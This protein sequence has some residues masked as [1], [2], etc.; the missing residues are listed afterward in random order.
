MENMS[1]V[2]KVAINLI[3]FRPAFWY[4]HCVWFKPAFVTE[5]RGQSLI[6]QTLI[7][8]NDLETRSFTM[9]LKPQTLKLS[10]SHLTS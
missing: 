6:Q 3:E 7:S 8:S 5:E 9:S 2:T 4:P 10:Q 1:C